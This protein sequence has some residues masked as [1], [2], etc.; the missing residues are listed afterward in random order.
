MPEAMD[1][2][3]PS[4]DSSGANSAASGEGYIAD[5]SEG[6]NSADSGNISMT[7]GEG[8]AGD[9]YVYTPSPTPYYVYNL[10]TESQNLPDEVLN[11]N[12]GFRGISELAQDV[13][14]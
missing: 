11:R 7:N 12:I 5:F 9:Y 10:Q 2:D 3:I 13:D 8:D 6:A 14:E 1:D 4:S